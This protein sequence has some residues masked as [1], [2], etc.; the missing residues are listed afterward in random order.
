MTQ[1]KQ[2]TNGRVRLILPCL[3]NGNYLD[4][5]L[6]V[7]GSYQQTA[8]GNRHRALTANTSCVTLTKIRWCVEA[9][10]AKE[11]ALQISGSRH[12]SPQQYLQ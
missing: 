9:N 7:A 12:M 3:P 1:I 5:N 11:Y 8:G 2:Q 4:Q 6:N 10:F